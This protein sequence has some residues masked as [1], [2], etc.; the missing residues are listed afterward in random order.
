VPQAALAVPGWQVPLWQHWVEVQQDEVPHAV[1]PLG[2]TQV[3]F[4]H[5]CEPG[6]VTGVVPQTLLTQ[7]RCWHWLVGVGQSVAVLQ[8]FGIVACSH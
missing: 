8:Q 6:H 2:H 1:V 3:P 4:T 5:T 7:V